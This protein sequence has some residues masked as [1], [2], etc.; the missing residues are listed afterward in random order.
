MKA[1]ETTISSQMRKLF[2]GLAVLI[3]T[4]FIIEVFT[5]VYYQ[6]RYQ[7]YMHNLTTASEFNPDF[8]ICYIRINAFDQ[9]Y[10]HCFRRGLCQFR[11]LF[12]CFKVFPGGSVVK[13]PSA[14]VGDTGDGW[15]AP[16]FGKIPCRRKW[17]LT[18]YSCLENVM[19]R[20]AW[21]ATVHGVTKS[22]T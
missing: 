7:H 5:I 16:W 10:N 3:F 18:L 12:I 6:F 19:D 1:K 2:L 9:R 17:Q 14:I 11:V 21:W 4:V 15:F 13:N 20:E 8:K 22:Q